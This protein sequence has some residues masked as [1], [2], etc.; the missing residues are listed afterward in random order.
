MK[1]YKIANV[2][3]TAA[4]VVFNYNNQILVL[5]RGPTADWEPNRWNLPGGGIEDGESPHNAAIRECQ[6]EAGITPT[7]LSHL[8][9]YGTI[10]IFN[11]ESESNPSINFES[12]EFKWVNAEEVQTLDLVSPL[13][14][15]INDAFSSKSS[16]NEEN[17]EKTYT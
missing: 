17:F 3:D 12:S 16:V 13:K 11:G 9:D 4:V 10:S 2:L 15:V 8:G 1:L 7:N 5:K 6:E 14:T